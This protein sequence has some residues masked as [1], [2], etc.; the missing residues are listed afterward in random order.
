M[1]DGEIYQYENVDIRHISHMV[2]TLSIAAEW[3]F[4]ILV[5]IYL[6]FSLNLSLGFIAVFWFAIDVVLQRKLNNKRRH[7]NTTKHGLISKRAQF[8]YEVIS[9]ISETRVSHQEGILIEKNNDLFLEECHDHLVFYRYSSMLE[10]LQLLL[11]LAI[12]C[13]TLLYDTLSER[14]ITF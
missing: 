13:S 1:P 5:T 6:L 8:N 3:P 7:C 9:R 4:T 10:I 14:T 12:C 2:S 11:P